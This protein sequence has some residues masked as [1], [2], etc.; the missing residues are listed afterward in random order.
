MT[1][2]QDMPNATPTSLSVRLLAR[3]LSLMS[4]HT[5]FLSKSLALTNLSWVV[6]RGLRACRCLV[7]TPLSLVLRTHLFDHASDLRQSVS[8]DQRVLLLNLASISS[9]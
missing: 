7:T 6:Y 1:G 9:A 3:S 4:I 8:S 2:S 5:L